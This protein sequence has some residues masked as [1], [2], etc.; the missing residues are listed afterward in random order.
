MR[1]LLNGPLGVL[2]G[3]AMTLAGSDGLYFVVPIILPYCFSSE[4]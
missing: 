2:S 1:N 4:I 3:I